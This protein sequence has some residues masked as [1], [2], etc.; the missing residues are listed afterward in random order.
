MSECK[1]C[2]DCDGNGEYTTF[3]NLLKTPDAIR[4]IT[5]PTCNGTGVKEDSHELDKC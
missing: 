4:W 2:P 3:V 5:C 1:P